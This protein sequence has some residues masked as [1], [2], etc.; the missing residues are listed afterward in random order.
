MLSSGW[1]VCHAHCWVSSTTRC[2]RL[3]VLIAAAST[4]LALAP[5]AQA[6]P[7]APLE[8]VRG[9]LNQGD[10]DAGQRKA[11]EVLASVSVSRADVARLYLEL[12]VLAAANDQRDEAGLCFRRALRLE[13]TLVLAE[14]AGPHVVAA[15]ALAERS[16]LASPPLRVSVRFVRPALRGELE[17]TVEV[18]GESDG[19]AR[20]VVLDGGGYLAVRRNL[21][22]SRTTFVEQLPAVTGACEPISASVVDEHG[23]RL[24]PELAQ[25]DACPATARSVQAPAANEALFRPSLVRTAAG[26]ETPVPVQVWIGAAATGGLVLATT[27]FG[28]VALDRRD[29]YHEARDNPELPWFEKAE[30]RER[31]SRAERTATILGVASAIAAG[32]TVALYLTRSRPRTAVGLVASPSSGTALAAVS[33]HF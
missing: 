15:F 23:N 27:V 19:L 8:E 1:M 6:D 32:A 12:G 14:T 26:P 25:I 21:E 33:G 31:A 4:V 13:P 5:R 17:V 7:S 16:V 29:Y 30:L 20:G 28:L 11:R 9:L 2:T 22:G 24:W 10:F 3:A 18:Q